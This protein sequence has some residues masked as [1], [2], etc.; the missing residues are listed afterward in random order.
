MPYCGSNQYDTL[1]KQAL[2]DSQNHS[3]T[4][5]TQQALVGSA[6]EFGCNNEK[7]LIDDLSMSV[8]CLENEFRKVEHQPGQG[9]AFPTQ[10][11]FG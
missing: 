5:N 1:H 11:V 2:D 10:I 6:I 3:Q 4:Y 8:V 9:N 7:V